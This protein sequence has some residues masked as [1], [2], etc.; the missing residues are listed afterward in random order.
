[1][2]GPGDLKWQPCDRVQFGSLEFIVGACPELSHATP[3]L[4]LASNR[5]VSVELTEQRS[6]STWGGGAGKTESPRAWILA[7]DPAGASL[8]RSRQSAS[9]SPGGYAHMFVFTDRSTK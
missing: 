2:A 7:L 9:R 5:D 1:M 3:R 4:F 8:P 6:W